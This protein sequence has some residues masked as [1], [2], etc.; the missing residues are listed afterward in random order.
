MRLLAKLSLAIAAIAVS[1]AVA[2]SAKADPVNITSGGFA[3]SNLANTNGGVPG[4]DALDG[5]V[6][7]TARDVSGA[8]NFVAVLNPMS[9]TTGFLPR[10]AS[11]SP[12]TLPT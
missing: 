10:L 1:F 8:A 6:H 11:T 4:M 5:F 7:T 9:F 12:S 2:P 3:L